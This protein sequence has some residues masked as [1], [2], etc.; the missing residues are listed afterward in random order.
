MNGAGQGTDGAIDARRLGQEENFDGL[1]ARNE[2]IAIGAPITVRILRGDGKHGTEWQEFSTPYRKAMRVLDALNAIAI[3]DARTWR[4][5][6]SADP[7]CAAPAP[8]A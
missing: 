4:S 1:R 2:R 5:A 7:R 6:G 3:A 8:F